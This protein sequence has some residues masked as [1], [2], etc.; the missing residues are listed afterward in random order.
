MK[1]IVLQLHHLGDVI[2]ATP[3]LQILRRSF[4][5]S[6]ITLVTGIWNKNYLID[7][8][9][10]DKVIYFNMP[11]ADREG[12]KS[13]IVNLLK[14]LKF[15]TDIRKNRYDYL[16]ELTGQRQDHKYV[17]F[18]KADA[19]YGQVDCDPYS[20]RFNKWFSKPIIPHPYRVISNFIFDK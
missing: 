1:I 5:D 12:K 3:A 17:P 4:L 10:I 18:I 11:W 9:F 14:E 16:F 2:L 13:G 6:E 15:I 20:K 7:C 19:K 8:P